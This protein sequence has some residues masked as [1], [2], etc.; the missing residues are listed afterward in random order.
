MLVKKLLGSHLLEEVESEFNGKIQVYQALGSK[1]I[2][3]GGLIQSGGVLAN[4][5]YKALSKLK[6]LRQLADSN[7]KTI[8]ILGLGGG[9]AASLTARFW[10]KAEIIGI[11]IDPKMIQL[12]KK[13]F[14]LD[15]LP[16]LKIVEGEAIEYVRNNNDKFDLILVDLYQ[17]DRIVKKSESGE[18]IGLAKRRLKSKGIIIFN[19]LFYDDHKEKAEKFVKILEK[20][21]KK[22]SLV[23]AWSNLI[24]IGKKRG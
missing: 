22:V 8:L 24:I 14:E 16:Q 4:I 20:Y 1:R 10:P 5:W 21:F 6:S 11:E 18:F 13:Y 2:T 15:K 17:G 7:L 12:G 9:T 23:R 19:R 3:A